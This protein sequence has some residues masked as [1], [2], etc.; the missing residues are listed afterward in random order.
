MTRS[1]WVVGLRKV[2][3]EIPPTICLAKARCVFDTYIRRMFS[4]RRVANSALTACNVRGT[5]EAT[6]NKLPERYGPVGEHAGTKIVHVSVRSNVDIGEGVGD[7]A[8]LLSCVRGCRVMNVHPTMKIRGK[9]G[10]CVI[11]HWTMGRFNGVSATGAD[12]PSAY[13]DHEYE[14]YAEEDGALYRVHGEKGSLGV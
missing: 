12:E 6:E 9:Y 11:G 2:K 10:I 7:T 13:D 3:L 5:R 8:I 1:V 4:I 14:A